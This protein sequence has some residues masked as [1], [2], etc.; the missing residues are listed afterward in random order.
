[1]PEYQKSKGVTKGTI[2][3]GLATLAM[4]VGAS[5]SAKL[6]TL[7]VIIPGQQEVVGGGIAAILMGLFE[8][9]R[10]WLRFRLRSFVPPTDGGA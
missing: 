5:L 8:L 10:N 4:V 9:L 6:V 1:M 3:G 2:A 7:G